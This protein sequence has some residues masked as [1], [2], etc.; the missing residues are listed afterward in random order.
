MLARN[1]VTWQS[2][3]TFLTWEQHGLCTQSVPR[4]PLAFAYTADMIGWRVDHQS[5][6]MSQCWYSDST[7][8][9]E[10]HTTK[11]KALAKIIYATSTLQSTWAEWDDWRVVHPPQAAGELYHQAPAQKDCIHLN[12]LIRSC[13]A[14]STRARGTH[15]IY[16]HA[17]LA[18][19]VTAE[20][21][22]TVSS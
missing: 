13:L 17:H 22:G 2:S 15:Y 11:W 10:S 9:E 12:T 3:C 6:A 14:S 20:H 4:S 18:S 21:D 7:T 16:I 1:V 8:H 19:R 5:L